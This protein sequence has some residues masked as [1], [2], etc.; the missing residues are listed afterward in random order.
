MVKCQ[1]KFR[2]VLKCCQT[3]KINESKESQPIFLHA[4]SGVMMLSAHMSN[5]KGLGDKDGCAHVEV[6]QYL[7]SDYEEVE[8]LTGDYDSVSEETQPW[9][10]HGLVS[11]NFTP[12]M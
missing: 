9:T 10:Q 6:V 11:V 1:F 7:P 5:E 4:A 8:Y 12:K 3:E 2:K